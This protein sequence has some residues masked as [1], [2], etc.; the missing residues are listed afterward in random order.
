MYSKTKHPDKEGFMRRALFFFMLLTFAL[1]QS[2][3]WS[4]STLR[5]KNDIVSLG[6]TQYEVLSKCGDPVHKATVGEQKQRRPGGA[7]YMPVEEWT[8]NF[9][10]TSFIYVLQFT[11]GKLTDIITKERGH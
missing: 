5:C 9:G 1:S 10:P 11:G 7:D 6:D 4:E 8:Y 3:A 2:L